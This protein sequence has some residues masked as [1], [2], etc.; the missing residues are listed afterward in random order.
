MNEAPNSEEEGSKEGL[1]VDLK[2]SVEA[3]VHCR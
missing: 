1:E 3:R 2:G